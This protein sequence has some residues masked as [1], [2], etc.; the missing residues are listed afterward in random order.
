MAKKQLFSIIIGVLI[1]GGLV[2]SVYYW[3][4]NIK[5]GLKSPA[6]GG[7]GTETPTE[8]SQEEA[9]NLALEQYPGEV[10]SI[11][12]ETLDSEKTPD[13]SETFWIIGINLSVPIGMPS[14]SDKT[15]TTNQIL[16]RVNVKTNEASIYK[17][18]D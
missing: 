17:L 9:V 15:K 1:L 14:L 2:F 3:F 5:P 12:K 6:S 10:F 7:E 8:I 18:G 13:E 4:Q 11:K 16:V